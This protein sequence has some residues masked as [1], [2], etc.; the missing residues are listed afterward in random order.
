MISLPQDLQRT[1]CLWKAA[2]GTICVLER[3]NV[4]PLFSVSLVRNA[5]VL[6]QKRLYGQAAAMMVAQRWRENAGSWK[7]EA[8]S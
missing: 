4:P 8:G 6:Q 3:C 1:E 2:D 7:F 5:E